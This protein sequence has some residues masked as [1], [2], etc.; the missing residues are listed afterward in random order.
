MGKLTKAQF[1]A[2]KLVEKRNWP[3]GEPRIGWLHLATAR[4]LKGRD[5]IVERAGTDP[6]G[7]DTPIVDLTP[8]G[9]AALARA[10]ETSR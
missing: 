4:V 2:L 7:W 5:L 3:A 6:T 10:Q 9:R 1:D 8:A